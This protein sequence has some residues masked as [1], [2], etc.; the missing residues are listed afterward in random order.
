M[1][2]SPELRAFLAAPLVILALGCGTI[3]GGT[4][5]P[6]PADAE[7]IDTGYSGSSSGSSS[8]GSS[9]GSSSGS[10]DVGVA[11]ASNAGDSGDGAVCP[12]SQGSLK[13]SGN[14]PQQ[15]M[16]CSWVNETPCS[17]ATPVCSNGIC[18][19]YRT[20]GGIRSTAPARY[21]DGG[22]TLVSGGFEVGTRTCD[23]AGICVTGGIVP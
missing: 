21:G 4:D 20:T 14:T 9:G 5:V 18:G 13:C 10:P 1:P 6:V 2:R 12:C 17:G 11:D 7:P 16:A 22:I 19:S 3:L 8:S 15:C 23:E